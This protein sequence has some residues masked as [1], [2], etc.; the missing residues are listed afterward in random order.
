MESGTSKITPI[1]I[2]SLPRS[3]STLLQKIIASSN[4]VSTSSEPWILLP[5]LYSQKEQGTFTEYSHKLSV[6]AM[7]DVK[8]QLLLNGNNYDKYLEKY[9]L[10]I[11]EG[12]SDTNSKYFLDKTPRYYLIIDEISKIFPDA[13]FIFLFRNP[14]SQLASQIEI[15]N[16]RFKTIY[17]DSIDILHGHNLLMSSY[18]KLKNKSIQINYFELITDVDSAIAKINKY[19]NIN[20]DNSIINKLSDVK[21]KGTLGDPK[22]TNNVSDKISNQSLNKWKKSFNNPIRRYV[23][24]KYL[25]RIDLEYFELTGVS[26]EDLLIELKKTKNNYFWFLLDF[27]DLIYCFIN[28]KFKPNI[29]FSKNNSWVKYNRFD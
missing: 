8:K 23:A 16:S 22:M 24:K 13:K 21:L 26:K 25:K 29:I 28:M 18:N 17:G 9:I 20:I 27:F 4:Q 10:S 15:H 11:Y 3:G 7:N 19:L 14:L 6:R 2:F 5:L 1:F 12:L